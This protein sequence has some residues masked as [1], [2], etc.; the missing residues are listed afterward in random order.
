MPVCIY[1]RADKD[2]SAFNTEHVLQAAFG[3]F[4][5]DAPTLSNP[6][7]CKA[8]NSYFADT[9][10]QSLARDTPIGL[11]RFLFGLRSPD[12]YKHLG[13]RATMRH[14]LQGGRLKGASLLITRSKGRALRLEPIPQLG[15]ASN[16]D[17]PFEWIL[18]EELPAA[19]EKLLALVQSG[20]RYVEFVEV[21][22]M[23]KMLETLRGMGLKMDDPLETAP[24]GDRGAARLSGRATSG[25]RWSATVIRCRVGRGGLCLGLLTTAACI[26]YWSFGTTPGSVW[27][28]KFASSVR[29]ATV[30]FWQTEDS[31]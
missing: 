28:P 24:A 29:T 31:P 2:A 16:A 26:G 8:C 12:E 14:Q 9:L 11:A 25:V 10:D 30:S 18:G 3:A 22:D 23:P 6:I 17:G 20:K 13:R 4:S 15:L 21:L 19:K 27:S 1:C 5:S 7:V